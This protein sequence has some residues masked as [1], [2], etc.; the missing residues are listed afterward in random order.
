MIAVRFVVVEL[1]PVGYPEQTGIIY[2]M[3]LL[4]CWGTTRTRGRVT[5]SLGARARVEQVLAYPGD[6]ASYNVVYVSQGYRPRL[7]NAMPLIASQPRQ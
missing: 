2:V 5:V 3:P 6:W 4:F 7:C 1:Y